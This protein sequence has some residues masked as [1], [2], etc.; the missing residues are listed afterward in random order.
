MNNNKN[1]LLAIMLAAA[2]LFV[3]QYFVATPAMKAEQARQA[4]LSHQAKPQA[5]NAQ[6]PGAAPE[7]PG[8]AAGNRQLSR[9]D[10][11]KADGARVVIDTP[12]VDGSI[13]L[14]GARFD[15]LRLKKYRDTVDP[16]SPEIVLLAPKN[17]EYPYYAEFGWVGAA[18]MPDENSQWRQTGGSTLSPAHPVTLSW[19][20][21]RGLVFSRT[22]AIDDKYMFTVADSVANRGGQAV[23]LYPYGTVERQKAP[24]NEGS[25]S[26]HTGFIG[27][28]N[29]SEQDA[30]YTD[31]K[32]PGTPAKTFSS[33]GGW[34]GITDKYWMAAAVP[35]SSEAFNG[36]Y[37]GTKTQVGVDAYQ[38]S[39]RL[40]Q[41]SI[42]PGASA[43]V[44][45]RLFAGAKVVDILRGYQDSQNI[46]HFDLAVDWGWF[47]FL[48]RPFFWLLD[49]LY[50]VLGNFGLAILALTVIVRL[51]FF[52]LQSASFRSMSKMKKLQ[53]QME[54]LKKQ[55]KEDPQA[56]QMAMMEL[57]KREKANPVSGCL[58]IVL[59]I[60][61]FFSL[62]KVLYVT[63]E[64]RHAPFFGWIQDLSAPDP[65]SILNLFGLLPF[66]PHGLPSFIAYFSIGV[67]PILY[68]ITQFV[69]T[70]LNPPPPDPVQAKMF[71][72]MPLIFTFMFATFPAGLVIYYAWSNLLGVIQQAYIMKREGVELALFDNL[73]GGKKAA[74]KAAND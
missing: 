11:L 4:A 12:M 50:K 37:L 3:W 23:T 62:Y 39:Y 6:A 30:K 53:P 72:F 35:P 68:G 61:V 60:P 69:Q 58:P 15:D 32:D 34:V 57:Y 16:K 33:T 47:F 7:L 5:R 42:A 51:V 29:G 55:H 43:S 21:G 65:T 25:F 27:V 71:S 10:A 54:V 70:K 64:M 49:N 52:P 73:R 8:I 2:T 45:H 44:S 74:P 26:L 66:N 56:L 24:K 19:D 1:V 48:T 9:E 13:L 17:T 41:R 46:A 67:W 31:F 22:I 18:N 20:N 14:K 63:I 28:A 38:A 59:T 40:N 36:S